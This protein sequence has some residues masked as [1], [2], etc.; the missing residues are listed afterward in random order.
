M[1]HRVGHE[2]RG[3]QQVHRCRGGQW[4]RSQSTSLRRRHHE[5][6]GRAGT[7]FS[8]SDCSHSAQL[9]CPAS[10]VSKTPN[11]LRPWPRRAGTRSKHRHQH[12]Y[13]KRFSPF[14][15]KQ[16]F[17]FVEIGA[18]KWIGDL[19]AAHV[20]TKMGS[21][22]HCL[23]LSKIQRQD[24]PSPRLQKP[25]GCAWTTAEF[26]TS[27]KI[28]HFSVD[29]RTPTWN[30]ILISRTLGTMATG[31]STIPCPIPTSLATRTRTPVSSLKSLK[32][33]GS[34]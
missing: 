10:G 26:P 9:A 19:F 23:Q 24:V 20:G 31:S 11:A 7:C 14:Q 32:V 21:R 17:K 12:Y 6:A 25:I 30:H 16:G 22:K 8:I 3:L 15:F 28:R 27:L 33:Q 1:L 4:A 29:R 34:G 5:S 13:N 18:E 2:P